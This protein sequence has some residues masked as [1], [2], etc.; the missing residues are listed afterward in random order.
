M[1]M[2]ASRNAG[3]AG[4]PD[5]GVTFPADF[6]SDEAAFAT[7]L[8]RLFSVERE[9]L[10]PRYVETLL[11]EPRQR[12]IEN[13]FEQKLAYRVFH[14]LNLPRPPLFDQPETERRA[15]PV[16][17]LARRLGQVSATAV[18][19][20]FLLM[21]MSAFIAGPSF[22]AGLRILLGQTGVQQVATYPTTV[23]TP[24]KSKPP[25]AAT[26]LPPDALVQ[27]LGRSVRN[28]TY[29]GMSLL[30][31][32]GYSAGPVVELNYVLQND[33][34]A[35]SGILTVREF[36]L[37]P[38]LSSVLQVVGDGS[39]T[40][41]KINSTQ[42]VFVDGQWQQSGLRH[43]WSFGGKG[44]LIM[45][46]G[47]QILWIVADQRDGID[48]TQMVAIAK[49]LTP[50]PLESLQPRH[51]Q[52]RSVAQGLEANLD[53]SFKDELL[54]VVHLGSSEDGGGTA[55]VSIEQDRGYAMGS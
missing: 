26:S 15:N 19:S 23:Q 5:E 42:G 11:G 33:V 1:G 21:V 12:P 53:V 6:T 54:E 36:K 18:I 35:G 48:A 4:Q 17:G 39:V 27:W 49:H 44:E 7:D 43:V 25:V 29:A 51:R 13:G 22:A 46:Q 55:F 47:D 32:Q 40:P 14:Q 3:E 30:A 41:V 37:A 50:T 34:H 24:A 2:F 20:G 45:E 9:E 52:L 16:A 10:P 31:P 38:D 8:R 28:Y